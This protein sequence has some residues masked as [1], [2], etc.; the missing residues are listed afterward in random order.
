MRTII[1]HFVLF[2]KEKSLLLMR[3]HDMIKLMVFQDMLLQGIVQASGVYIW[4][5]V[6]AEKTDTYLAH[7]DIS[8]F[9]KQIEE[10]DVCRGIR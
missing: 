1:R 5:D 4:E 8:Y 6:T 7:K 2:Y 10:L 3:L 9:E